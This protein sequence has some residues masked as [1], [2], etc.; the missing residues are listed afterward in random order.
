MKTIIVTAAI[1]R[2]E[3]KILI[4][5]RKSGAH[6]ELQWEFPGGKLEAGESPEECLQREIKEELALD[7]NIGRIFEVVSHQ[8]TDRH[9]LLLCYECFIRGGQ[10]EAVDCNDYKWV[11]PADMDYY[12]FAAADLP[13]VDR[14]KNEKNNL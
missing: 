4:A 13:V 1:I 6:L 9:I 14:I 3:N 8:Y 10:I 5:Q 2:K 12:Q 11:I 7:I